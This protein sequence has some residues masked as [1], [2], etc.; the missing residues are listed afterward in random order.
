MEHRST[1]ERAYYQSSYSEK[2]PLHAPTENALSDATNGASPKRQRKVSMMASRYPGGELRN[3]P[4]WDGNEHNPS[5]PFGATPG[6]YSAPV[7]SMPPQSTNIPGSTALMSTSNPLAIANQIWGLKREVVLGFHDCGIEQMYDWQQQCL[8][9]PG[10]LD[11]D[12][13]L[14][15]TAPTS[16]GKSL[17][18]DILAIKKVV[19]TRKKAL[20]VLPYIAIVQEKT[21]FLKKCA[22]LVKVEGTRR[23]E[24]AKRL[25]R[26][27]NIVGY[28]SGSKSRIGWADMD[29]AV[30]TIEK[31]NAMV[32]AAVEDLTIDQL[33]L[34][35]FDELHMLDDEHRGFILELLATKLL[36]LQQ[37]VQIVGMTATL[38]NGPVVAEWLK[39][40][41]YECNYRPIPL[42]EFLVVD[43]EIRTYSNKLTMKVAQSDEQ[44]LKDPVTNAVVSLVAEAVDGD[45]GVLVF[46]ESRKK[47][48]TMAEILTR[49]MPPPD[50][51]MLEKRMDL[52]RDLATSQT[53]LDFTLEKTVP[54]GIAFH[55]AGL[56]SEE[57]DFIASS[58]ENGIIKVICC[59]A[60][61]AAGVNLPA[62]RVIVSPRMGLD[63]V[64]PAMLRQM[65]GRA[66]R[67]GKDTFGESYVCCRKQDISEVEKLLSAEMPAVS[68]CLVNDN[69]SLGLTRALLE[70][71]STRL[72]QSPLSIDEYFKSTLLFHTH[73]EQ[74]DLPDLLNKA[75]QKLSDL[76]LIQDDG[77][78]YWSATKMG[79]ATVAAGFAP[80]DGVFLHQELSRALQNF[81]LETDMHIIYQFT[82]IHGTSA[83]HGLKIDWK[84]L[85][86]Q[87]EVLDE[88]SF[89]AATFIGV[90]P[91]FLNKMALGGNLKENTP[92]AI[93]KA[94]IYRRF[95]ISLMLRDLINEQPVH[96]VAKKFE[97]ARGFLQ[98][99]STTCRGFATTSA[100]FCRVMGWTGLAVL[101]E[102]YS[103]RLDLGVKDDL[104]DL[105]KLPFVKS[106][107]AR[108]FHDMGLK[109][110]EIISKAN[111]EKVVEA[112]FVAQPKK[113]RL[114]DG[115]VQ[116]LTGR[117]RE[118]AEVVI[119]AAERLY[120]QE[121][122][123]AVELEE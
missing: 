104:I 31:A 21:R 40:S 48:E 43:N 62:R 85:R 88:A 99:L 26:P 19:Q 32:N 6:P 23:H 51:E 79:N 56:T 89:K 72:A 17:V 59:T 47:C 53:G 4:D 28:H 54:A 52:V 5:Q 75:L 112:F 67:K 63:F 114:R 2:R 12:T 7:F 107:T 49:F 74:K 15:Y 105:A 86:D 9:M 24:K 82:P 97:M 18:A 64:K 27:L 55:H 36:C 16:A 87:V 8:M 77:D 35:V 101:M 93:I 11:G 42:K 46:S 22:K 44:D 61:M 34:V 78:G 121:L 41:F 116:K 108:V 45:H 30:C 37:P 113:L 109:N 70:I 111:I 98:S 13:N 83:N 66:G 81:N 96:R 100:L 39:A 68:S 65:R 76:A 20:I 71:I 73:P 119:S 92:E 106:A 14:V 3:A 1:A 57:R 50:E 115:E 69:G 118:K 10:V 95:Y 117:L 102:H 58:Y 123:A 90:N 91:G 80:E 94:R 84:F 60:T 103:W 110:V 33:G 29:I 25:W 122:A 120:N 38:S